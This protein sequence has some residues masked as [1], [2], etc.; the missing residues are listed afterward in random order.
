MDVILAIILMAAINVGTA[1]RALAIRQASAA[2]TPIPEG[3]RFRAYVATGRTVASARA[4]LRPNAPM[5][6]GAGASTRT[7]PAHARTTVA[8]SADSGAAQRGS[9]A[10]V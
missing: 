9:V 5:E 3:N 1:D 6:L 10:P 4:T 8:L 2:T 7:I